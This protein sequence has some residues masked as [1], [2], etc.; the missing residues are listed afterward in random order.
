VR[1]ALRKESITI[2]NVFS[3]KCFLGY[4]EGN[5]ESRG[6]VSG[7]RFGFKDEKDSLGMKLKFN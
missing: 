4:E 1:G 3:W 6:N 2:N 5:I 7:G